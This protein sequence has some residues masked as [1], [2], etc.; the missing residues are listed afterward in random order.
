MCPGG[1][2]HPRNGTPDRACIPGPAPRLPP[3]RLVCS[4]GR[5]RILAR[6]GDGGDF[7]KAKLEIVTIQ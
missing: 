1:F 2:A 5:G 3:G 4:L 7:L 6:E